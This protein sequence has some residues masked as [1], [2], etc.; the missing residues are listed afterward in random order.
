MYSGLS[1]GVD[2]VVRDMGRALQRGDGAYFLGS[3][4]SVP[5][6]LPDWLKLMQEVA[7][8]LGL[9]IT[10]KD[11]LALMAQHCVNA[12]AG[13]RGALIG[14][15][16]R[17]LSSRPRR[18]NP[19]HVAISRTNIRT[20]WSTNF[21]TLLEQALAPSRLGVRA[22]DADLTSGT[23]DFDLELLK[24]HGCIDRSAPHQLVLT[25]ED[26]E[27]FP[28]QRPALAQRLRNDLLHR[29]LLF[30]GYSYNDPNIATILV[31]A[32]RLAAKS[33]R[34]HFLVTRWEKDAEDRKRQELWLLDLRRVGIRAALINDFKELESLL[35]RLALASRGK[36]VFITGSHTAGDT[37]AADIGGLLAG[38]HEVLF[39][40]GQS[41]GVG[42]AAANAFGT[43]CI[44]VHTD[45]RD[46]I[47]YFPNPYAFNPKFSNDV[48]LLGPLKQWRAS[49]MRAAH[50]V[51]VFDGGM[52]TDAEVE[53]ARSLGCIIV[54]VPNAPD[55]TAAR[56]LRDAKIQ[57]A[58]PPDYVASA[59][60]RSPAAEEVVDC[61]LGTFSP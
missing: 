55:G 5:S 19:Y 45:I 41:E 36:S 26:Y 27:E 17:A 51:V 2:D 12:D 59:K 32:R 37:K 49:L 9:D 48:S 29:S 58:L 44:K 57:E 50:T 21:D 16:K 10:A 18:G 4:I 33:T 61:V 11:D 24:I 47:R 56:L 43:A 25:R 20:L 52:G 30:A 7:G 6:G 54:P 14:R 23:G 31:E 8:P 15:L 35:N 42:R 1:L 13:N 3:G 34:E 39:L 28:A 40:D 53:L 38:T 60:V 46:R 22:N